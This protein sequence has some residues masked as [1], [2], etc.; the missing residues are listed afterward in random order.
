MIKYSFYDGATIASVEVDGTPHADM[1]GIL[2]GA[3]PGS[4]S[5]YEQVLNS[6][7][8]LQ[9]DL[10]IKF[11]NGYY[12]IPVTNISNWLFSFSL[13]TMQGDM[14]EKFRVYRRDLEKVLRVTWAMTV[15]NLVVSDHDP[16]WVGDGDGS[17]IYDLNNIFSSFGIPDEELQDIDEEGRVFGPLHYLEYVC[18]GTHCGS[19]GYLVCTQ[20]QYIEELPNGDKI[21]DHINEV[22]SREI[23]PATGY[24]DDYLDELNTF[25]SGITSQFIGEL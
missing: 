13:R 22:L 4:W 14:Y 6:S 17:S 7:Q 2:T 20:I 1:R 18:G 19:R 3:I 25:I 12:W 10:D 24:L 23:P 8:D 15:E 5:D 9:Y 21:F 11:V 16:V